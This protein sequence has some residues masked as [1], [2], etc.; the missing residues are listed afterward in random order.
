LHYLSPVP[1]GIF[2]VQ[3]DFIG[4]RFFDIDVS[5]SARRLK[6]DRVTPLLDQNEDPC[7]AG[8]VSKESIDFL[9]QSIRSI[10]KVIK[11]KIELKEPYKYLLSMPESVWSWP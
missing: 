8:S 11:P 3:F 6:K 10:E 5:L 7:L 4:N 2:F 1:P 9:T